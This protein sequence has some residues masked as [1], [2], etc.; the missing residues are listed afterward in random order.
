MRKSDKL[1]DRVLPI[2]TVLLL[3]ATICITL[4]GGAVGK[5]DDH[6]IVADFES[7]N[8][9]PRYHYSMVDAK[10][11]GVEDAKYVF[12]QNTDGT[13]I[14]YLIGYRGDTFVMETIKW[15]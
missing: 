4:I 5:K 13:F 14:V 1:F 8:I 15:W 7:R 2:V 3:L 11:D 10:C 6:D 12:C 9:T